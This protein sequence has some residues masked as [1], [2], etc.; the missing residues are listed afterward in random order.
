MAGDPVNVTDPLR[1]GIEQDIQAGHANLLR[2]IADMMRAVAD[3]PM[4][5]TPQFTTD[6]SAKGVTLAWAAHLDASAEMIDREP[7]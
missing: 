6:T 1:D 2:G 7:S 4:F 3:D 5:P